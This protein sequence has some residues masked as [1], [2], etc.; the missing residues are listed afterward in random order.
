MLLAL[1]FLFS[2]VTASSQIDCF[3]DQQECDIR[4]DNLIHTSLGIA[5]IEECQQLCEDEVAWIAFTHF[6]SSAHP[7]PDGCLLFSSCRD[8]RPC[9]NCTTGS[10][11][12][13]CRCSIPYAGGVT[14]DNFIELVPGVE[15]EFACKKL[16]LTETRCNLYTYYDSQ[17]LLEPETCV[18]MTSSGLQR[19]VELCKNCY[20][21]PGQCRVNQTCQA[22]IITTN[23]IV[24]N[25]I[26]AEEN[27]TVTL[28]ANEKGC[29]VDL[30]V[31]AIGGGGNYVKSTGAGAGSG[32]IKT[33]RVPLSINTPLMMIT[34]GS[35]GFSSKVDV[36]GQV[37]LEAAGGEESTSVQGGAGYSGGGGPRNPNTEGGGGRGGTNGGDGEDGLYGAGGRGSGFDVGLLGSEAFILVPGKGG[38]ADSY[39]NGGGGGGVIVNGKKP[40]NNTYSGEGY[41]GGGAY[42]NGGRYGTPGNQGYVLIERK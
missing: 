12:T 1:L 34:V 28:V 5:S 9:Q 39:G 13:E 6:G 26:F 2:S 7:F 17:D 22:A 40:G 38:E 18:L 42:G 27:S 25:A 15:D 32:H 19:A 33:G 10:S 8:R 16:C 4:P 29:H 24:S 41:G 23:G 31:V 20:T 30:E 36:G 37:V 3:V 11:Q 14:P 21:G 35:P